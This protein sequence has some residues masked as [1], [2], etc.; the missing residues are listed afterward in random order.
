MDKLNQQEKER[1]SQVFESVVA[2]FDSKINA[3]GE[4]FKTVEETSYSFQDKLLNHLKTKCEKEFRDIEAIKDS[5]AI[6]NGEGKFIA[7]P[8]KEGEL[9]E[10]LDNFEKCAG[11]N[12][13]GVG[14]FLNNMAKETHESELKNKKCLEACALNMNTYDN[15]QL[16]KCIYNCL[17][18]NFK[19]IEINSKKTLDKLNSID[20]LI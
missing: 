20:K 7:K 15:S 14:H 1:L 16:E 6:Q 2:K 19:L 4:F 12:D 9:Q 18:D 5:S 11:K 3:M 13:F 17:D 8:G 10:T